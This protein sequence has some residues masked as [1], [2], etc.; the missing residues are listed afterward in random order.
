M[1]GVHFKTAFASF[2]AFKFHSVLKQSSGVMSTQ[3]GVDRHDLETRFI[4]W[5]S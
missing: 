5:A 1:G 4:V 2:A 3:E